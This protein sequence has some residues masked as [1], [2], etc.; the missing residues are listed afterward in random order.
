MKYVYLK[1]SILVLKF[2][3]ELIKIIIPNIVFFWYNDL[4]AELK[5]KKRK[6][7]GVGERMQQ[8]RN[9]EN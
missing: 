3:S 6:E 5:D 7:K 1:S 2:K 8:K 9:Q 4:K